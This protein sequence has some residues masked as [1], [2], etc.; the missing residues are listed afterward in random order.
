[1]QGEPDGDRDGEGDVERN[2][3]RNVGKTNL[4][5]SQSMGLGNDYRDTCR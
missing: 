3:D 4:T 2:R 5:G 1:M